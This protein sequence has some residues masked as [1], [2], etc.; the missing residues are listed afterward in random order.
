MIVLLGTLISIATKLSAL[1]LSTKEKFFVRLPFSIYFGWIT[2]ATIANITTF[3]VS[4]GWNGFGLSD[5]FWTILIL[6][7]GAIIGLWRAF[8]DKDI[9]YLLVFLWA[10]LGILNKHLNEFAGQYEGV[11]TTL[12]ICLIIFFLG[13][14]Y[15][16]Y[17]ECIKTKKKTKKKKIKKK[18]STKKTK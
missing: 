13:A 11:I 2:V 18:K 15:L 8:L 7:I 4:I 14:L 9:A 10:Y 3:F 5:V 16:S 17:I 12:I 6:I 1:K